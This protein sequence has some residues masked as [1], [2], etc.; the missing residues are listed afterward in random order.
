MSTTQAVDDSIKEQMVFALKNA[1]TLAMIDIVRCPEASHRTLDGILVDTE[2][3]YM[4]Y[5]SFSNRWWKCIK[6]HKL[7]RQ[8]HFNNVAFFIKLTHF[9]KCPPPWSIERHSYPG[10][11]TLD[12]FDLDPSTVESTISIPEVDGR[13]DGRVDVF[14][15]DRSTA[16]TTDP[17]DIR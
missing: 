9:A 3:R 14:D 1:C 4:L 7:Q 17:L 6:E 15:L 11:K 12:V 13:V 8:R 16:T 5:A 10:R 2:R